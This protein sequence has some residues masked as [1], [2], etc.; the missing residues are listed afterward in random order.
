MLV[1]SQAST[2]HPS[3]EEY[4]ESGDVRSSGLGR[5]PRDIDFLN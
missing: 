3:D 2:T 1:D 4:Y 5:R